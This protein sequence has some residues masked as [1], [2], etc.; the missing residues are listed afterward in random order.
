MSLIMAIW[1][2]AYAVSAKRSKSRARRRLIPIQAKVRLTTHRLGCTT[3]P[4]SD[5]LM[6]STAAGG[7]GDARSLVAG[8]GEEPFEEGKAAGDAVED[9]GRAVAI[10]QAGGV[11]LDPEHEA[12]AI[13]AR[14]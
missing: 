9:Q 12:R 3:K 11:D 7:I 13:H 2:R 4:T 5:R 6:I 10:L 1:K 14:K 8:V